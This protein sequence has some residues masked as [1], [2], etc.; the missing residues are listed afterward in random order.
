MF[1]LVTALDHTAGGGRALR[2]IS[3]RLGAMTLDYL[4]EV[5]IVG[6]IPALSTILCVVTRTTGTRLAILAK[7]EEE[8]WVAC[9]VEDQLGAGFVRGMDMDVKSTIC[10]DVLRSGR[11][12]VVNDVHEDE[13]Y[14]NHVSPKTYGFRSF[15]TVP[16]VLPQGSFFGTLSCV[17][18][19]PLILDKPDI[20]ASVRLL[21]DLMAS[22]IQAELD[23]QRSDAMLVNE[24]QISKLRE[25][26]IAVLGHDLRNP[27]ASVAAGARL[28]TRKP[29]Q[30][31]RI[32]VEM[33]SSI[34]RMS[35]LIDDVTDFA[36]GRLGGGLQMDIRSDQSLSEVLLQV[37]HEL[38]GARPDKSISVDIAVEQPIS[39]DHARLA[40]LASNLVGNALLHGS[41]EV[42]VTVR[43][44]V[45]D[46]VFEFSVTNGGQPIAAE[47]LENLFEPFVH[48][49]ASRQGLGLG[50]YIASEIAKAHGGRIDVASDDIATRFAF[51]MPIP[52][53]QGEG[54]L[55]VFHHQ[56]G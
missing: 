10:Y 15:I 28:I 4:Q 17:D 29:D 55:L 26:F 27:L 45:I 19:D 18:P 11:P 16:V 43:A 53:A 54:A 32:A 8:R 24:Q 42:P 38:Q 23:I 56:P 33:A 14:R 2:S 12:I 34:G 13:V 9:S 40:Q 50:L 21:S 20:I 36:R 30:I 44:G 3:K 48:A 41:D 6:R 52:I 47:V 46:G 1:P 25:Q 5:E 7:V 39:C 31:D 49:S 22:H 37:V 51:R 35:G